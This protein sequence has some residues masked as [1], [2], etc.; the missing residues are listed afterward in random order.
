MI[1]GYI[2]AVTH[3]ALGYC[4]SL[5]NPLTSGYSLV[6]QHD[7]GKVSKCKAK[8]TYF[9]HVTGDLKDLSHLK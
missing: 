8:E 7:T 4:C 5:T 9:K 2:S 3:D 6:H 1:M